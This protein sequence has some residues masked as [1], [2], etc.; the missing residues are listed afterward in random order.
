MLTVTIRK[1]LPPAIRAGSAEPRVLIMRKRDVIS[2][3]WPAEEM[4]HTKKL[5]LTKQNFHFRYA[6]PVY[7]CLKI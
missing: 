4:K 2:F 3:T 7:G 5:R 6:L 1:S